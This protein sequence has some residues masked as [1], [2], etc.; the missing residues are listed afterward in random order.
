MTAQAANRATI[1][2]ELGGSKTF[3]GGPPPLVV[4][5]VAAAAG[6]LLD[7]TVYFP[8]LFWVLLTA[9]FWL[10]W[11]GL[12]LCRLEG[13]AGTYLL[14]AT[15]GVFAIHHHC[16][17]RYFPSDDIGFFAS[18]NSP[19]ACLK[20]V[21]IEEPRVRPA[22]PAMPTGYSGDTPSTV[23]GLQ[24]RA[25]RDGASWRSVSGRLLLVVNGELRG[26]RAGDVVEAYGL[27]FRGY[28]PQNPGESDVSAQWRAERQLCVLRVPLP[29][30]VQ[31]VGHV[32][33]LSLPL[34]IARARGY[35]NRVLERYLDG[36][37]RAVV[38]AL[39]LGIREG[40][41]WQL[42]SPMVE[43]GLLHF[44][45]ISGL[46]VGLMAGA[47]VA[48][49]ALFFRRWRMIVTSAAAAVVAYMFLADAGPS[50]LRAGTLVLFGCVAA[51]YGRVPW[52]F[53]L[54]GAAGLTVL[55]FRPADLFNPGAHLSF[56]GAAALLWFNR[57]PLAPRQMSA[58]EWLTVRPGRIAVYTYRIRKVLTEVF[59]ASVWISLITGPYLA[60]KFHI[61][62]IIAPFA[63]VLM[64]PVILIT[65]VAGLGILLVD[66][67]FPPA[68]WL[69]AGIC[70]LAAQACQLIVQIAREIPGAFFWVPGSPEWWILGYYAILGGIASVRLLRQP[71]FAVG[72]LGL[73]ILL[74]IIGSQFLAIK[75]QFRCTFLSV[76][77]GL[78]VVIQAP[79]TPAILYDAGSVR[80]PVEAGARISRALWALGVR[81]IGAIVLSHGDRDHYNLV[82]E[83]AQRF[84]VDKVCAPP[85]L[86]R[87]LDSAE[88][89]PEFKNPG[90]I[91]GQ[92]PYK[93]GR[94]GFWDFFRSFRWA[95]FLP[96]TAVAVGHT[97]ADAEGLASSPP[98]MGV[99]ALRNFLRQAA[100]P[101]YPLERGKSLLSAD[102]KLR[103][104]ALAPSGSSG[105]SSSRASSS[106]HDN[107]NSLVVAVEYDGLRIL[108]TGDLEPPG[109]GRL[110]A[111][112]PQRVQVLLAPHHGSQSSN[113]A[114][115][116]EWASPA[117][118]V[119]SGSARWF[120]PDVLIAY[121]R[122]GAKVFHT[123][124]HG[125]IRLVWEAS[126]GSCSEDCLRGQ[127]ANVHTAV[128]R[129]PE[130]R[131]R[132]ESFAGGRWVTRLVTA[133]E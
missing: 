111:L 68:A 127:R 54:L 53:N 35:H 130:H 105:G 122:R 97:M 92:S 61:L 17:W 104:V 20:A 78:L 14:A 132:V 43:T 64:W 46:H 90:P 19:Q 41:D 110:L 128:E 18:P 75:R 25:L 81:R 131:L 58:S 116:V 39:I 124:L 52:D 57:G 36:R 101:V 40:I 98:E 72:L 120:R 26:L 86:A 5:L 117:V 69:L 10:G 37:S 133:A 96:A 88:S 48:G 11:L 121:A 33:K 67:I 123:R 66:A 73:W 42:S 65:M 16:L 12:W 63:T 95:G 60:W 76:G 126:C 9:G 107:A 50:V 89:I 119:I 30:C 94:V 103:L 15:A 79:G 125:A 1:H 129:S 70:Q 2:A 77:H 114:G 71:R 112:E 34:L 6:I 21:V 74:G 44:L 55:A 13:G 49:A 109:T 51:L 82:P 80:H 22:L 47:A 7:R 56:L 29:E 99:D 85:D 8:L 59:L 24:A 100:I 91:D 4:L 106:V 84:P 45:A 102:G 27:L 93:I 23:V 118:V 87:H 28:P 38:A 32:D 83:I 108:L 3:G 62:S 115:L 113:P 31:K